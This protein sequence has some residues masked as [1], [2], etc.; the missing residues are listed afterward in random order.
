M[1]NTDICQ[2]EKKVLYICNFLPHNFLKVK[3]IS[4][5]YCAL[6]E[7]VL[8]QACF[9]KRSKPRTRCAVDNIVAE[10]DIETEV[11]DVCFDLFL[12]RVG[13]EIQHIVDDHQHRYRYSLPSITR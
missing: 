2:V 12:Q 11:N 7:C 10:V 4:N 3:C 1:E 6:R 8:V 9:R 5:S 13:D